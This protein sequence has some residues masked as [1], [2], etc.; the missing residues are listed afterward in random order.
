R[1]VSLFLGGADEVHLFLVWN[2]LCRS[3]QLRHPLRHHPHPVVRV[4]FDVSDLVML[5]S[6]V[7]ETIAWH[8]ENR[9]WRDP[10]LRESKSSVRFRVTI[11]LMVSLDQLSSLNWD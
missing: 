11:S 5:V 1:N 7:P 2:L 10:V 9:S 3:I 8:S 4:L 6:G